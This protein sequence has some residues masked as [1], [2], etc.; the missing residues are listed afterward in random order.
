MKTR[1]LAND[2][3]ILRFGRS[4]HLAVGQSLY[5]LLTQVETA[6]IEDAVGMTATEAYEFA[7]GVYL[8]ELAARERGIGW[9]PAVRIESGE[10]L[11]H[12]APATIEFTE[13][14]SEW[15]LGYEQLRLVQSCATHVAHRVAS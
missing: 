2:E 8:A 11:S 14:G 7:Y 15:R 10:T 4:E 12:I 5:F 6:A 13:F 1:V 3:V 9:L